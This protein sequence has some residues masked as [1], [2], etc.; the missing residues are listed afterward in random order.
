MRNITIFQKNNFIVTAV[1]NLLLK[2]LSYLNINTK[3]KKIEK[4]VNS[5]ELKKKNHK[6][7]FVE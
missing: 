3:K 5:K 1:L 4:K 7:L 6:N 2:H